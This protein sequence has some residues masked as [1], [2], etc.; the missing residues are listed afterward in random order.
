MPVTGS[1]VSGLN[2]QAKVPFGLDE[3][4]SEWLNAVLSESGVLGDGRVVSVESRVIGQ[5]TG[6]MG[7][8]AILTPTYDNAPPSAP[9]TLVAKVPSSLKNRVMGQLI[10]AYEKEIRFYSLL[11]PEVPVRTPGCY[12]SALSEADDPEVIKARLEKLKSAPIWLIAIAGLFFTVLYRLLPRRYILLIEDLS[13][14]RLGDQSSGCS[15]ADLH[16]A[17]KAM[18]SLHARFWNAGDL[19]DLPWIASVELMSKMIHMTYL[20]SIG[21]YLKSATLD[22]RQR[23]MHDWLKENGV[24]LNDR[25]AT[26]PQTLLHGDFRV[27]NLC[28]DDKEGEMVLLDWQTMTQG[29]PALEL[30]YF[31]SNALPPD[32]G[33]EQD[34]AMIE[35]YRAALAEHGIEVSQAW[36]TAEYNIGMMAMLQRISPL[37]FQEQLDLGNARGPQVMQGWLDRIYE[38][39]ASVDF[40]SLLAQ[41]D[42]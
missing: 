27:D 26:G 4:S 29:S 32:T 23:R 20:Q 5:E 12:Y 18:A 37:L 14:Y 9:S 25:L 21:G 38:R 36:L 31:L 2:I 15:E 30:A 24:A 35:V 40:E 42:A 34:A 11:R 10:G 7:D 1:A 13:T 19:D 3:I 39:L 28:F 22:E 41:Q 16:T 17:L 6:F 33:P 8:I